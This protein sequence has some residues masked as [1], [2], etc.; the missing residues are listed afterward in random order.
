MAR[1]RGKRKSARLTVSLDERIYAT[2]LAIARNEDVSVAWL[3]RRA[4]QE[5]V[6]RHTDIVQPDLPLSRGKV[7]RQE[8]Q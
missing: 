4:I 1:P 2:L 5:L 3:A 6:E 7:T 8:G